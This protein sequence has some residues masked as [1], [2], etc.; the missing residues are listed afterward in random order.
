[1]VDVD[2]LDLLEQSLDTFE[3]TLKRARRD[4]PSRLELRLC[5]AMR[6]TVLQRGVAL[7]RDVLCCN[8]VRCGAT[9]R[10]VLQRGAL[11]CDVA[12][13]VA[14]RCAFRRS[15]GYRG[16]CCCFTWSSARL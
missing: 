11:W 1:M 9:W 16:L 14:T 4:R 6:R 10:V 13:C 3:V 2:R 7:E 5:V 8:V 12:C 15:S